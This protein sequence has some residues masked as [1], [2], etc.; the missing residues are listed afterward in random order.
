M[1][2]RLHCPLYP[3]AQFLFYDES[4]FFSRI[5]RFFTH[6]IQS[7][8]FVN[9]VTVT[10]YGENED[11]SSCHED[12]MSDSQY[13]AII[14]PK[15]TTV[16]HFSWNTISVS[17]KTSHGTKKFPWSRKFFLKTR[18]FSKWG[19]FVSLQTS[20]N[21]A[22]LPPFFVENLCKCVEITNSWNFAFSHEFRIFSWARK[23]GTRRKQ[24]VCCEK[25][26]PFSLKTQEYR[27]SSHFEL[28]VP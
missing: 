10:E 26:S 28:P 9:N 18:H 23:I 20:L 25:Y 1:K 6:K 17:K 3:L 19:H 5:F 4:S 16:S 8:S 21:Q 14:Y 15:M 7:E 11:R 13:E 24:D 22:N 2:T 12:M 27:V